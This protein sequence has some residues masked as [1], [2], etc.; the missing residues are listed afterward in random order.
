VVVREPWRPRGAAGAFLGGY[1]LSAAGEWR[2]G[3]PYSMRTL[4]PAPTPSC[5]YQDWLNAG[6]ATG[7]GANCLKIVQQPDAVLED[8]QT[9]VR[10][11][12]LGPSLN[13][14]G[15]EDLI[16]LIGRNT[17]RYPGEANLDLRVTKRIRLSDRYDLS[18]LGEAFNALNHQNVTGIQTIGYRVG[19]DTAH[20]NMATLT[21]QSGERPVTTTALVNG[22]S[23][24]QYAYD[25][26][27]AFGS[28]TNAASSALQRERQVQAGVK[29]N[30]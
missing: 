1:S 3:L 17:F 16:P 24:T 20:A 4:G 11:P 9:G 12:S 15:G 30:F 28:A 14:S 25:A 5:S 21:W 13:G 18:L 19:N 29:L 23:V 6:G 2:T 27:A 8:P 10:I 7:D 22:T 26:T